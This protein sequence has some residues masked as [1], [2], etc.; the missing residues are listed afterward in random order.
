MPKPSADSGVPCHA[1]QCGWI[2]D[3]LAGGGAGKIAQNIQRT[4]PLVS[5]QT[6]AEVRLDLLGRQVDLQATDGNLRVQPAVDGQQAGRRLNGGGMLSGQIGG[7]RP[8]SVIPYM[9][10]KSVAG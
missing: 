4:G 10:P 1:A 3:D 8:A 9:L 7:D 5:G 2:L 6:L